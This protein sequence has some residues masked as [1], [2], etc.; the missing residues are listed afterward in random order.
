[1]A[2]LLLTAGIIL[3]T[4]G[5]IAHFAEKRSNAETGADDDGKTPAFALLPGDIK[6]ESQNGNFKF[7]FPIT[8]SIVLSVVLSLLLRL[9]S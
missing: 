2:N 4:L 1:M 9:F 8:T 6:Y 7:Y 3:I 5:A